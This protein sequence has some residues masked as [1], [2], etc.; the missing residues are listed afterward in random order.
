MIRGVTYSRRPAFVALSLALVASLVVAGS[1]GRQRSLRRRSLQ[2]EQDAQDLAAQARSLAG[3]DDSHLSALRSRIRMQREQEGDVRT[4][5]RLVAR[6][7]PRWRSDSL[8]IADR[9][10][11]SLRRGTF[12]L[13]DPTPADWPEI[14]AATRDLESMPGVAIDV[15]DMAAASTGSPRA[16]ELVRLKVGAQISASKFPHSSHE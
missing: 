15:L 5:D 1:L 2:A 3:F 16:L 10:H 11:G 4:W 9:G 7:G 6:L 12:T 8:T 14:E 13:A